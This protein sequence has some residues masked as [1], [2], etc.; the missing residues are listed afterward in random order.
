MCYVTRPERVLAARFG[1]LVVIGVFCGILKITEHELE[2][3][4]VN[5]P[6]MLGYEGH[7]KEN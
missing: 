4:S 3:C 2:V 5:I 1:A 6:V 7:E